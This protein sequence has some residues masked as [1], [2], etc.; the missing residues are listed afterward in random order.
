MLQ[1]EA[2][3]GRNWAAQACD[4]PHSRPPTLAARCLAASHVGASLPARTCVAVW[5]LTPLASSPSNA[6]L[7]LAAQLRGG[8][9]GWGEVRWACQQAHLGSSPALVLQVLG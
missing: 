1:R 6:R 9:G 7:T 3:P 4:S 2:K 5:K 8:S